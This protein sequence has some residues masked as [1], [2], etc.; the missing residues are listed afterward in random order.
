MLWDRWSGE[1]LHT[2]ARKI[3]SPVPLGIGKEVEPDFFEVDLEEGDYLLLCS[4]GLSNMVEDEK[5]REIV[6]GEGT[7]KDKA[8]RLIEEAN[9]R[10]GC[11][12]IAVVLV[13]PLGREEVLC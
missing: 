10:G 4:D 7:L 1:A 12:N 9:G 13:N 2:T 5:I 11:D 3:L 6:T 8:Y